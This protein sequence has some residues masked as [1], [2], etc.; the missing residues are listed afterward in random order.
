MSSTPQPKDTENVKTENPYV[1]AVV[2]S[3][4]LTKRSSLGTA[5][6]KNIKRK[7]PVIKPPFADVSMGRL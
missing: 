3:C 1:S 6:N 2:S 4:D 7:E 5:S